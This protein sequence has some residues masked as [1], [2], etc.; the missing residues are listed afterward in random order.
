M[1]ARRDCGTVRTILWKRPSSLLPR[2]SKTAE[3]LS[4]RIK[5]RWQA[6]GAQRCPELWTHLEDVDKDVETVVGYESYGDSPWRLGPTPRIEQAH[7]KS[8]AE[9]V[10]VRAQK[11]RW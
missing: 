10:P 9:M 7:R 2:T 4:Q 6:R 1:H 8:L 5:C 3:A 11:S